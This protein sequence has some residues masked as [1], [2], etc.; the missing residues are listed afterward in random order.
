MEIKAV[1]KE[2]VDKVRREKMPEQKIKELISKVFSTRN[3]IHF[4]HWNTKS[5]AEHEA[6]GYIYTAI[7]NKL[8]EI[9][10]VYQGKYGLLTGLSAGASTVPS[11][12]CA[13]VKAEAAWVGENR[14]A[15][16][17]GNDAI[18]ALLDELEASYLKTIYKLE[19]L[20]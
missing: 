15:I 12:C 18:A 10:E 20:K 16:S 6:L 17:N 13:H 11:D 9:V 4:A 1:L 8:D 5:Y 2:G 7:V 14:E 3:A 19:N